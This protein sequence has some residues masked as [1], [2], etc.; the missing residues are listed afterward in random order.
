MRGRGGCP[1]EASGPHPPSIPEATDFLFS[2]GADRLFPR[3]REAPG[4]PRPVP[5]SPGRAGPGRRGRRGWRRP[6]RPFACFPGAPHEGR[7]PGAAGGTRG[8]RGRRGGVAAAAGA[9][10]LM[11]ASPLMAPSWPMRD[12]TMHSRIPHGMEGGG[13]S[14][15]LGCARQSCSDMAGI[16]FNSNSGRP[17]WPR[18]PCGGGMGAP[19]PTPHHHHLHFS[20][21][22]GRLLAGKPAQKGGRARVEK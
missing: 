3:P 15:V 9:R 6:C 12:S 2:R 19:P 8:R 4:L 1:G 11:R 7:R 18:P 17:P 16:Q 22:P 14:C 20:L 10:P 5:S 21:E 13:G